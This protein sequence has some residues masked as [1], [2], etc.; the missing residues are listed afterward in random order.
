MFVLP[1]IIYVYPCYRQIESRL[2]IDLDLKDFLLGVVERDRSTEPRRMSQDGW[3]LSS[4]IY[5]EV[6]IV[7]SYQLKRQILSKSMGWETIGAG[8][9]ML[10][11]EKALIILLP[12]LSIEG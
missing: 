7:S 8:Q 3:R 10:D 6:F 9:G 1:T 11:C 12:F 2:K 5:C 4:C